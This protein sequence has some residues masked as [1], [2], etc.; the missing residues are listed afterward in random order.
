MT[1][2]MQYLSLALL[3]FVLLGAFVNAAGHRFRR[4]QLLLEKW[5]NT[6]MGKILQHLL[7][8]LFSLFYLALSLMQCVSVVIFV[9]ATGF[10]ICVVL[11]CINY[12]VTIR[13]VWFNE[14]VTRIAKLRTVVCNYLLICFFMPFVPSFLC[15]LGEGLGLLKY[16]IDTSKVIAYLHLMSSMLF[17]FSLLRTHR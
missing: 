11:A 9:G 7:F 2:I 1:K 13:R 14:S 15:G 4:C 5:A 6:K 3:F 12:I 10:L 17:Y 16:K 8:A